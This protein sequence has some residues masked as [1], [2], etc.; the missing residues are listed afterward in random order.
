MF[1]EARILS[2]R[3]VTG[4]IGAASKQR[5]P[6]TSSRMPNVG[7][8]R[9]SVLGDFE[10][11]RP[12]GLLLPNRRTVERVAVGRHVV[13]AHGHH[14]ATAQLAVDREIEEGEVA[15]SPLKL[16]LGPDRPDI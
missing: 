11:H 4:I 15:H 1:D 6:R 5:L 8:D 14:I 12:P 16:Q 2:C 7:V 10:L 3:Q 9:L 13:E